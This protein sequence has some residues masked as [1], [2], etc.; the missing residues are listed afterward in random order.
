M[1]NY[2][3]ERCLLGVLLGMLLGM[4]LMCL[5]RL[6]HGVFHVVV[7]R[8]FAELAHVGADFVELLPEAVHVLCLCCAESDSMYVADYVKLGLFITDREVILRITGC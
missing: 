8:G 1:R 5:C 7:L 6:V 4:L 2:T 3:L